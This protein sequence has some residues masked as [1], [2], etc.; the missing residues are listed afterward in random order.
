MTFSEQL[1]AF[2]EQIDCTGQDLARAT[3]LGSSTISRY[4]SGE[5]IPDADS[6]QLQCLIQGLN[7]LALE[8]GVS[9]SAEEL[10]DA[11]NKTLRNPLSV[12][13]SAWLSNLNL[14]L[15]T[16]ELSNVDLALGTNYSPSSVSRILSGKRRPSDISAFTIAVAEYVV[17]TCERA[18]IQAALSLPTPFN[19]EN[20]ALIDQ[21]I[22]W[23]GSNKGIPTVSS[24]QSFL[25]KVD[26]FDLNAYIQ[27]IHFNDIK[28]TTVPFQLPLCKQYNGLS[29]MM[30]SELDFIKATV[31]SKSMEDLILYSDMPMEEM[32]KDPD[33]PKKWMFGMAML[34]KKGLHL[35]II[36]D[37]NRPLPEMFLGLEGN[38]PLYMTGQITPFYLKNTQKI[39]FLHL[40]KVSGTVAL[41]GEAIAGHHAEGRYVLYRNHEDVKY[42]QIQAKR[43]LSR[44]HPLMLIFRADCAMEFEQQYQK[45]WNSGNRRII[46]SSLPLFTMSSELL[47]AI[48]DRVHCSQND[49]AKILTFHHSVHQYATDLLEQYHITLEI[50][51]FTGSEFKT[52]APTL[53]LSGCFCETDILYTYEE[54]QHHLA[55]TLAF[56]SHYSNCE[57]KADVR[58]FR[59]I[60]LQ[61][62]ENKCVLVSKCKS[63]MIHFFIHHPRMVKAFESFT[64]PVKDTER[65]RSG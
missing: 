31:L 5:R 37:V 35:N 12:D 49:Q 6:T 36:H 4:R 11:L 63:P 56:S 30:T 1:N 52:A 38:I 28:L 16:L 14:L 57:L 64:A 33:F 48:L 32:A 43:L 47:T 58:T 59:N 22:N 29:E 2:I 18:K 10:N 25:Q 3:G 45:L 23:L 42:L 46:C 39:D 34:L 17:H 50:P 40:L 24:V 44:A 7:K 60:S 20:A 53:D 8:N 41:K 26:D 55:Q 54:Y 27:A 15:N 62:I 13:Y 21:I 65:D 19:L 9:L 61:I 51:C